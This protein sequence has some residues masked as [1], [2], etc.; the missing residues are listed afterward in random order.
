[1]KRFW[2]VFIVLAVFFSI[3][4]FFGLVGYLA[5]STQVFGDGV[6]V[7]PLKGAIT[8]D[9]CDVG[10]FSMSSCTTVSD[11]KEAFEQAEADS[12]VKAILLDV[13]SGGGSVVASREM[14]RVVKSSK[15]PVV[16]WIGEVGASGA[17]YVVSAADYVI[18]DADSMV[19]SI[20]VVAYI[21]HYYDLLDELGVNVTVIKAGET[22]DLGSPYRPMT[23]GERLDMQ[24]MVDK[25]HV[26][27]MDDVAVNR[28]LDPSFVESISEGEI[29]LGSEALTLGLIDAVGGFDEAVSAAKNLGGI[30]GE[31]KII[32]QKRQESLIELLN[33]M[34]G[35]KYTGFHNIGYKKILVT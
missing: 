35:F 19:G 10:L 34:Y 23:E 4:L 11:I 7:V 31:P 20:G 6:L 2:K 27:F 15:K 29:Y 21:L 26:D 13:N 16:A 9:G 3:A 5:Y 1:M 30:E 17:Y 18:S 33:R 25:I 12:T 8:L 14:M 24:E 22:K 32:H 28:D